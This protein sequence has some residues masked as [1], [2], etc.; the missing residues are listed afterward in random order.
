MLHKRYANYY[1]IYSLVLWS[2]TATMAVRLSHLPAFEVLAAINLFGFL[3]CCVVNSYYRLWGKI[4]QHPTW[5]IVL[6]TLGIL[7]NDYCYILAFHYAPPSHIDMVSYLW[8]LLLLL[9]SSIWFRQ[10]L[11][12]D[13]MVAVGVAFLAVMGLMFSDSWTL[14]QYEFLKGYGLAFLGAI[15]WV[16]Y[17][18]SAK[19]YGKDA[20]ELFTIYTFIGTILFSL[21]YYYDSTYVTPTALDMVSLFIMGCF[22]QCLAYICWDF[23]IKY[24]QVTFLA[25]C[26]YLS[27]A[28]SIVW[29]VILGHTNA[30]LQLLLSLCALTYAMWLQQHLAD[31]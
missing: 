23:A 11:A 15:L 1:G 28:L 14:W 21:L 7:G 13:E 8:P 9:G 31:S 29:L 12:R 16:V 18:I 22:S 5:V 3:G 19:S 10:P 27:P 26:A 6:G 24:G 2:I 17:L 30:S 4:L 20:R 25:M